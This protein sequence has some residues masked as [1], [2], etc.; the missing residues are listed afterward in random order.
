MYYTL[1]KISPSPLDLQILAQLHRWFYLFYFPHL[2]YATKIAFSVS[3]NELEIDEDARL[4][5]LSSS[6]WSKHKNK[7]KGFIDSGDGPGYQAW[8]LLQTIGLMMV[9]PA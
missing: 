7:L 6:S 2:P 3:K 1:P 4:D 5:S 8:L 9:V